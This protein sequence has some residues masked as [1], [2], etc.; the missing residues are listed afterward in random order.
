MIGEGIETA[1]S[2]GL[3][4][5]LPAWAAIS[6]GNMARTMALPAAV[7]SVVIAADHDA[8]GK[9]SADEARARWNADGLHIRIIAPNRPGADFNDVLREKHHG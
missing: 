4:I 1:A 5:G 8:P 7:A 3:L 2:A 9:R 6:A